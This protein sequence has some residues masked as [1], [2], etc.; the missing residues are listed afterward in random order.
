MEEEEEDGSSGERMEGKERGEEEQ[1]TGIS[2]EC[3]R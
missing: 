1:A 2:D 3:S